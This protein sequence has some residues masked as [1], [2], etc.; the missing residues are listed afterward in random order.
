LS[1]PEKSNTLDTFK[2]ETHTLAQIALMLIKRPLLFLSYDLKEL[3]EACCQKVPP[4]N[5]LPSGDS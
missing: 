2:L 1:L 3:E 5:E 4:G